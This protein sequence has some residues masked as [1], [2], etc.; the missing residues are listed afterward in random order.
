MNIDG[1]V[2][3]SA[4]SALRLNEAISQMLVR[5]ARLDWIHT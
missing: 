2:V 4:C 3:Q 5:A 1:E